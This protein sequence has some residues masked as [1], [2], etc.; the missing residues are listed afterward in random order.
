M[1]VLYAVLDLDD[2]LGELRRQLAYEDGDDDGRGSSVVQNGGGIFAMMDNLYRGWGDSYDAP[3][4]HK[5]PT[6]AEYV[7]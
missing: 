3:S 7:H 5:H 2:S 6:D 4:Y 1:Q